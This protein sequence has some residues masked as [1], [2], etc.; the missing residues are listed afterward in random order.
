[1]KEIEVCNHFVKGYNGLADCGYKIRE[2]GEGKGDVVIIEY[3]TRLT[4]DIFTMPSIEV[5]KLMTKYA[6][7]SIVDSSGGAVIA[8]ALLT[9][10]SEQ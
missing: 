8:N 7:A 5:Q 1:M 2:D 3:N 6:A 4:G 10:S 9:P